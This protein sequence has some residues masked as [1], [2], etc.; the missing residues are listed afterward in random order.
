MLSIFYFKKKAFISIFFDVKKMLNSKL[1]R[2]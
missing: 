1:T 2:I